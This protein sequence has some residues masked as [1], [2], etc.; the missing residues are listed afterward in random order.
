MVVSKTSPVSFTFATWSMSMKS[1]LCRAMFHHLLDVCQT[2]FSAGIK[3]F[4]Y[5]CGL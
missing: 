3:G 4:A 1:P 2:K 5:E